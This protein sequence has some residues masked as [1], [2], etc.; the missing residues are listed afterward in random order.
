MLQV[1]KRL[2]KTLLKIDIKE[3]LIENKELESTL[4]LVDNSLDSSNSLD[5]NKLLKEPYRSFK[6]KEPLNSLEEPSRA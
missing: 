1:N 3:E 4:S 2:N 5:L 6:V